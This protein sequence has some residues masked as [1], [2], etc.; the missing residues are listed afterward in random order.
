MSC[1][2]VV[3]KHI[4]LVVPVGFS[5]SHALGVSIKATTCIGLGGGAD[6]F[7][8]LVATSKVRVILLDALL[9]TN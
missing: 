3:P 2:L 8:F 6:S 1:L 5:L 7:F 4:F 9:T